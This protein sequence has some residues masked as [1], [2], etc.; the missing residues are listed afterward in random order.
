MSSIRDRLRRGVAGTRQRYRNW[1]N[2]RAWERG[3]VP[4]P[5]RTTRRFSSLP[6]YRNRVNPATG[7]PRRDDRQ[8]GRTQD[9]AMARAREARDLKAARARAN[10]QFVRDKLAERQPE[11]ARL[12]DRAERE[13]RARD[14]GRDR[15]RS[16]RAVRSR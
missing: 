3:K 5:D 1:L 16:S 7:R 4:L 12:L 2:R 9:Q 8:L 11:V 10:Q 15:R 13:S 14:A 6:V